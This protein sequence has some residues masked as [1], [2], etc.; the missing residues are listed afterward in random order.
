MWFIIKSGSGAPLGVQWGNSTDVP[1]P[2]DYDGDGKADTATFRPSSG[3]WFIIYSGSGM[4][5]SFPFGIGSDI[6]IPETYLGRW[7]P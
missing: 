4:S 6:P 7:V 2:G 5:V 1:I 3:T